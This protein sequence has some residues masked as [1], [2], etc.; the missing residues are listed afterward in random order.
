MADNFIQSANRCA[1]LRNF[2]FPFIKLVKN[3]N[4]LVSDEI[5]IFN[6]YSG[7]KQVQ[8]EEK[9]KENLTLPF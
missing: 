4:L 1:S 6:T 9:P 5:I 7:K 2:S 8:K 3:K